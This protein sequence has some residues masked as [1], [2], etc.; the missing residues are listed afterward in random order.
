MGVRKILDLIEKFNGK[1]FGYIENYHKYI[2]VINSK[3]KEL[4][5]I[6]IKLY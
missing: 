3:V 6:S 2:K 1:Y 5:Q 4:P